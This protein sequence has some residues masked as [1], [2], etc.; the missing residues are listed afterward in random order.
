MNKFE[1]ATPHT[2]AEALDLMND[3]QTDTAV[4][5]GG[6]DLISLM[7]DDLVI[8]QRVID[9]NTVP[10]LHGVSPGDGGL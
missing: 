9:I 2:E 4:L 7:H 5:A 3:H 6:T 8:P 10:S 1:Y